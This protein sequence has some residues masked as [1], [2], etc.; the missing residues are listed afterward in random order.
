MQHIT[1]DELRALVREIPTPRQ[2]LMIIVSFNHG[3]RV[4]ET[5]NL[6]GAN[7]RDGYLTVQRLKGSEKTTQA[8]THSDD[9]DM[10]E[11]HALTMLSKT[12][13]PDERLF[14]M[15]RWG[16][17]KL[18]RR[19]GTRAGIPSHKLYPHALK[20][21]CAM[22]AI[23]VAGIEYVRKRLGHKSIASTGQ[24]LRVSDEEADKATEAAFR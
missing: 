18:I 16:V 22:A 15:T 8:F 4:S 21:G 11:F 14:P 12:V 2:K 23:K 9:P 24:Y 7:I 10:D 19:A 20:H 5:I 17:Y 1:K 13:R 6:R 3:L